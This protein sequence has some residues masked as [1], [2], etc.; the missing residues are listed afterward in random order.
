MYRIVKRFLDLLLSCSGCVLLWPLLLVLTIAV[1]L[2]SRGPILFL[3]ERIGRNGKHFNILKFRTMRVDA[4]HDIPTHMLK[5]PEKWITRTGK[6][7]R[8]TSIDELPQLFNILR[9]DMS[10][11]GPRPALW[12]QEDLIAARARYQGRWGLTPNNLRPGLTGWAQINGRDE[13]D[14]V[15]KAVYDGEYARR[16]S[17]LFDLRCFIGTFRSVAAQEGVVE[18]GTGRKP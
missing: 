12:N 8:K 17:F 1:K 11:V 2:D 13:L 18:G 4:P 15:K 16:I 3:Q 7:L 10:I 14:I 6:F 5:D 9:G